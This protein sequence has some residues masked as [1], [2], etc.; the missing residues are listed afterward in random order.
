MN[1]T[2]NERFDLMEAYFLNHKSS[3]RA[4]VWYQNKYPQRT[5]PTPKVLTT[6]VNNLKEG[7]SYKKILRRS[8]RTCDKNLE[9]DILIFF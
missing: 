1:L 8:P 9:L 6:M 7:G 2:N 3:A 5:L 4:L